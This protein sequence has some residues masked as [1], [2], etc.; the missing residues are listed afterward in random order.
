MGVQ[1]FTKSFN[2]YKN[3][4]VSSE[5]RNKDGFVPSD[6]PLYESWNNKKMTD[7]DKK[8]YDNPKFKEEALAYG[9]S[10]KREGIPDINDIIN[11]LKE[12][13]NTSLTT[14]AASKVPGA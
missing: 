8:K 2:E 1:E 3:A 9:Q 14:R 11:S 7:A 6:V 10:K 13:R 4:P 12:I 5:G